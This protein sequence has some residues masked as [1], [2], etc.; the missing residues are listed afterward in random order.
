MGVEAVCGDLIEGGFAF[1]DGAGGVG[2]EAVVPVEEAGFADVE[3]DG[4]E[5]PAA[6]ESPHG[7]GAGEGERS[8]LPFIHENGVEG[9]HSGESI[10]SWRRV[11]KVSQASSTSEAVRPGRWDQGVGTVVQWVVRS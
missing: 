11:K 10:A 1:D 3:A 8:F 6:G 7:K 2:F 5:P 9:G 4:A